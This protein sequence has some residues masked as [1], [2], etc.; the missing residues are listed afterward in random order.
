MESSAL[1][2]A[3]LHSIHGITIR[4]PLSEIRDPWVEARQVGTLF[5][6]AARNEC[7]VDWLGS[8]P[9]LIVHI[10]FY[11]FLAIRVSH[12]YVGIVI[13]CESALEW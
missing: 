3:Q 10:V 8:L 12:M 6:L 7:S 1:L 2:R 9:L 5:R 13:P 4:N 11:A